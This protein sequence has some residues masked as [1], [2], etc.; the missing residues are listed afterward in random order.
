MKNQGGFRPNMGVDETKENMLSYIYDK[1]NTTQ[2]VIPIFYD[3]KKA[4]DTVDLNILFLSS[5]VL[6]SK[7]FVWNFLKII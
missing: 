3:L 6:V 5:G 1:L 4:F 7:A 2:T